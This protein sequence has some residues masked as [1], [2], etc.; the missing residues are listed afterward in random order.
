M[1]Q[2]VQK[3]PSLT[4]TTG[5]SGSTGRNRSRGASSYTIFSCKSP[6]QIIQTSEGSTSDIS[7]FAMI[8][9]SLS[10]EGVIVDVIVTDVVPSA[11]FRDFSAYIMQFIPFESR[12]AGRYRVRSWDKFVSKTALRTEKTI[13]FFHRFVLVLLP[14][15]QLHEL[16][17]LAWSDAIKIK[18][19]SRNR[20]N[21][22]FQCASA[23]DTRTIRDRDVFFFSRNFSPRTTV[24]P[25]R[26]TSWHSIPPPL[27]ILYCPNY[28]I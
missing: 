1:P 3:Y 20:N 12:L 7:G 14:L 21:F 5:S 22:L 13:Y 6:L 27:K 18:R 2:F 24:I 16:V 23:K 15:I 11:F 19:R 25:K 28:C 8:P 9:S 17:L 10:S 4:A 26:A